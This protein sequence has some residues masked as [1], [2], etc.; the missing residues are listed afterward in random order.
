MY[1]RQAHTFVCLCYYRRIILLSLLQRTIHIYILRESDIGNLRSTI[2]DESELRL[3]CSAN[4]RELSSGHV[5]IGI[6]WDGR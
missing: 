5:D 1:Q 4:G 3:G 2:I 6:P